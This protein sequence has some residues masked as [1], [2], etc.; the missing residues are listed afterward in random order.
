MK[1]AFLFP[2]QGSQTVGMGRD[3]A[4]AYPVAKEAFQEADDALGFALSD[5]CFNGPEDKLGMTEYT[6]PALLA[7]SVAITRALAQEGVVPDAVAGHSLGEFTG[8]VIAGSL[9]FAD[10]LRLVQAR[11]RYMQE[12]VPAGVGRMTAVLGLDRETL[13][14]VCE[15]AEQDQIVSLANLN[16]PGQIVIAGHR[17]AVERAEDGAKA[18]GASRIIPLPVSVPSHCALME[19]AGEQLD[20]DMRDITVEDLSIP[21]VNN[22]EA[23]E[24][25][26]AADVIPSARRQ[27]SSPVLWGDSIRTL[28]EELEVHRF[29]E[30]GPGKVLTGLLRRI[31]RK[32]VAMN[33]EDTASLA[34]TLEKVRA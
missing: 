30:V 7:T 11:G 17:E 15:A 27:I 13:G 14:E 34:A 10:A 12:A 26:V 3:I 9:T 18:A 8:L 21:L 31:D 28:I 23:R 4:A 25:L 20:R 1:T 2:G 33:V 24:I 19:K 22:C 6:Q 16:C 5:L 29:I 32:A